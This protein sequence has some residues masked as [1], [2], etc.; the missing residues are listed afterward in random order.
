MTCF[1]CDYNTYT[2]QYISTV[3]EMHEKKSK[4]ADVENLDMENDEVEQEP[5]D[6][7][8]DDEYM[9]SD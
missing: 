4:T 3:A 6:N 8:T 9:L 5:Q 1:R 2:L 7:T